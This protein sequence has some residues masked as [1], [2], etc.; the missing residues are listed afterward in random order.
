MQ[1]LRKIQH[2]QQLYELL[3]S[4]L[5]GVLCGFVVYI[6]LWLIDFFKW[7][8]F[9]NGRTAL[10]FLGEYYVIILPAIGGL[11][12]GILINFLAKEARGHGVPEVIADVAVR[13]GLIPYKVVVIKTFAASI[14]IG[15]GGSAGR[16]GPAIHVGS[17]MGSM[18]GQIF[19][20][21]PRLMRSL[22]ACGAAGGVAASFHAPMGG[23]LFALEVILG[24]LKVKDLKM[25]IISA[26]CASVVSKALLGDVPPIE[27]PSYT[28]FNFI[29]LFFYLMLGLISGLFSYLF[30]KVFYSTEDI[31]N[32]INIPIYMKP[33]LGGLVVGC[34]GFVY[35]QVFG[36]GYEY[37]EFALLGYISLGLLVTL[38][39]LKLI[40]T[41]ITLG[42]GA[43]GGIFAPTIYLGAML[44]GAFGTLFNSLFPSVAV[45]PAAYT[46]AGMAGMLAGSAFAPLTGMVLLFEISHDYYLILPFMTVSVISYVVT[47]SLT[48]YSIY[49]TKL[50][51]RGF[52]LNKLKRLDFLRQISVSDAMTR[53][54]KTL[55]SEI[56]ILQALIQIIKTTYNGFPVVENG[57]VIGVV[58]SQDIK[59]MFV[60]N[61][62]ASL[63]DL[64]D[65]ELIY[66]APNDSLADAVFLMQK[67]DVGRLPVLD[68]NRL[69]GIITRSDIVKAYTK[70]ES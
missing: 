50:Y 18:I 13:N 11:I 61:P 67:N 52:D 9:D 26:V 62:S 69:A 14:C 28:V 51:R 57:K 37:I 64:I 25:I 55:G 15:S 4:A 65:K 3:L 7:I 33:A 24:E 58:S 29:E 47:S 53:D 23:V 20:V 16:V 66:L 8:F 60:K 17:G 40:A 12:V 39:F 41:S 45:T 38:L 63:K 5:V 49:T 31:F 27:V 56:S 21:S 2:L 35:P 19:K 48:S 10:S 44:G 46:L 32:A 68:N 70:A 36:V 30:I 42:S 1:L 54:V 22:V 34:I 6:F 59:R 43:S